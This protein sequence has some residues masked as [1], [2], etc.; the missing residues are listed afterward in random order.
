MFVNKFPDFLGTD[1]DIL[2]LG[3]EISSASHPHIIF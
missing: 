2:H 1:F 3:N